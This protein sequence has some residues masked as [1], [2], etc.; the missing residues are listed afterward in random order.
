VVLTDGPA[1]V[2]YYEHAQSAGRLGAALATIADL[3][4]D[5]ER[6]RVRLPSGETRPVDVVYGEP[7]RSAS[8]MST[9]T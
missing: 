5:G 8:A 4:R 6:L 3:E 1:N 7:T 2:A 9:A